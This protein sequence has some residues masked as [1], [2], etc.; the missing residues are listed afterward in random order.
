MKTVDECTAEIARLESSCPKFHTGVCPHGYDRYH[1][2]NRAYLMHCQEITD[3][4]WRRRMLRTKL[5]VN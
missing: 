3:A 1:E 5:E 2:K 4:Y